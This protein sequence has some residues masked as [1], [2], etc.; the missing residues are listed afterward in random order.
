MGMGPLIRISDTDI[1]LGP[2]KLV[3]RHPPVEW[4]FDLRWWLKVHFFFW[5]RWIWFRLP[6][7]H[8]EWRFRR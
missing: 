8:I 6:R 4:P 7:V 1:S 5:C 3:V 2:E